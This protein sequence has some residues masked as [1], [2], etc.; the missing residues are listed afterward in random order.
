MTITI[1][2][3][4]MNKRESIISLFL[5]LAI[6]SGCF[7]N[8]YAA[9]EKKLTLELNIGSSSGKI[10]GKSSNMEKPYV[11]GKTIMVPLEWF[12]TA[13]GA[14]VIKKADKKTVEII[15]CDSY[16]EIKTGTVDYTADSVSKK[17]PLAPVVKNK[18]T[19]VP[20]EFISGNFP[21]S[22]SSDIKK[23]T[24]KI[25]LNDDGALTDLSFLTGGISTPKV[26]NSFY[27]W[28]ISIPSGSRIITNSFKSDKI[29]ITT[30]SRSLY[31]EVSVENKNKRT[32]EELYKDTLYS[33]NVRTSK[34]ELKAAVPYFQYTKLTA[35]DEALRVKVFDKGEYF[36]WV[37]INCYDN[38][39]TPEKLM[40]DK[41][42][43]NIMSSFSL[44]YKGN[45]KGVQDLSKVKQGKVSFYNYLALSTDTKYLPWSINIPAKWN[46]VLL[47][48]DPF[49]VNLG[50]DSSHYMKITMQ[51]QED[52]GSL[53]EYVT[54]IKDYYNKYFNPKV[55][56]FIASE[57]TAVAGAQAQSLKFSLKQGGKVFMVD[58][59]Y[60]VKNDII[61]EVSVKLP[62]KEY[63]KLKSEFFDTVDQTAFYSIDTV[64]LRNDAEKFVNRIL[65]TR[66]SQQDTLFEYTNKTY[67]WNV[68]IPG[69][70]TRSGADQENSVSFDNPDTNFSVI[71]NA[72]ENNS[73]TKT[74][75][76]EEK[77][78]IMQLLKTKYETTPVMTTI[79][80]KGRQIRVYNYKI[81]NQDYDFFAAVTCY[82]FEAGNNTYCFIT[83]APELTATESAVKEINDIWKSFVLTDK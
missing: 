68:K 55:Y 39:V 34:L 41:Y 29:G 4:R 5:I 26:G 20:M 48:D 69:Y 58:E 79:N 22:V 63:D 21:V 37:T 13:I 38:S 32:L 17:L 51:T 67:K 11:S 64:K 74:F 65:R 61:Y 60:F 36:Y 52:A 50:L 30:E 8:T 77:F 28:S 54:S 12:T 33:G 75:T 25:I 15:Y 72:A 66:L 42:Y 1:K 53:E 23:G 24:A 80:D 3:C 78:G 62:E 70:W 27:G 18:S 81:E 44:N 35:Y 19:M 31:F 14:E 57:Q 56:T 47:N 49:T 7:I 2:E 16:M 71:I 83:V 40:N 46:Q 6:L 82:C 73:L 10:D 59:Y 76:D 45:T 43:E 9:D